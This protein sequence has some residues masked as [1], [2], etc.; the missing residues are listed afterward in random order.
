MIEVRPQPDGVQ[1]YVDDETALGAFVGINLDDHQGLKLWLELAQ[2]Y[3]SR[4]HNVERMLNASPVAA[5]GLLARAWAAI[6]YVL[7]G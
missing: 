2:F 4:G 3:K 1:I 7:G 5:P 6:K